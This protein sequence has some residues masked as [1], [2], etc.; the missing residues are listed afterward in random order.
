VEHARLRRQFWLRP[1]K[2]TGNRQVVKFEVD[3]RPG[4]IPFACLAAFA[5][6][7]SISFSASLSGRAPKFRR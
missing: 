5:E 7:Q 1:G 2:S 4:S 3:L 6:A